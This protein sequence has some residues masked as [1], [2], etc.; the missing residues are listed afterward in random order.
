M[1]RFSQFFTSTKFLFVLFNS[2]EEKSPKYL[3]TWP[4]DGPQLTATVSAGSLRHSVLAVPFTREQ[5]VKISLD[6]WVKGN[7]AKRE[8]S[9]TV[10]VTEERRD[11][12]IRNSS[13]P[14][15]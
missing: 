9:Y 7:E 15:K 8:I 1:T 3:K 10:H 6:N 11:N 14:F 13:L 2:E 4:V 12:D 5:K